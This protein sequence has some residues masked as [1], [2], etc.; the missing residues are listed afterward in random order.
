M[1]KC[2]CL[3]LLIYQ[4]LLPPRAPQS[5]HRPR[6]RREPPR[7]G[8][9]WSERYVNRGS[10][11]TFEL[12]RL[13]VENIDAARRGTVCLMDIF[14]TDLRGNM[15]NLMPESENFSRKVRQF[16]IHSIHTQYTNTRNFIFILLFTGRC[17]GLSH[18]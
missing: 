8:A 16:R 3:R 1:I 5:H 4:V 2:F 12:M 18:V 17:Q 13:L 15:I 6:I 7:S 11:I 14:R 10:G 9:L